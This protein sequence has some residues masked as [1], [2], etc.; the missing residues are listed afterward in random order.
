MHA[1]H[2]HNALSCAGSRHRDCQRDRKGS[3][4][5][6]SSLRIHPWC[7][8]GYQPYCTAAWAARFAHAAALPPRPL[9]AKTR[10]AGPLRFL[11]RLGRL[12]TARVKPLALAMSVCRAGPSLRRGPP[13]RSKGLSPL[14]GVR[15]TCKGSAGVGWPTNVSF[16][17]SP[18]VTCGSGL[19]VAAEGWFG[20]T[21][22]PSTHLR[23]VQAL[24]RHKAP[25]EKARELVSGA[26]HRCRRSRWHW[27]YATSHRRH[28]NSGGLSRVGSSAGP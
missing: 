18:G 15:S 11:H 25:K 10:C 17:N 14:S 3:A 13:R 7:I 8:I 16:S 24:G 27:F 28:I 20:C 19:S 5:R 2:S 9:R 6:N 23:T 22:L 12:C 26:K 1:D 4:P 21:L